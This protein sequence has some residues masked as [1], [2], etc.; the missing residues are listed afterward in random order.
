MPA[1]CFC[2]FK[3]KLQL[4]KTKGA[5]KASMRIKSFF[6]AFNFPESLEDLNGV[7]NLKGVVATAA[8]LEA[9]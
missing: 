6:I 4:V 5:A 9:W 2:V 8:L 3:L 1:G 7:F